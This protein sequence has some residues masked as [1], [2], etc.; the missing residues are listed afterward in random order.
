MIIKREVGAIEVVPFFLTKNGQAKGWLRKFQCPQSE[1]F[2]LKKLKGE[3]LCSVEIAV[4]SIHQS[5]FPFIADEIENVI[6]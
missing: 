4:N 6:V 5:H 2:K 3:Q 1:E